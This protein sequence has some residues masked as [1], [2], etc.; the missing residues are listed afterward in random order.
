MAL[1]TVAP[2]T[3]SLLTRSARLLRLVRELCVRE[4]SHVGTLQD[5]VLA[6]AVITEGSTQHHLEFGH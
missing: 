6:I 5:L 4:P 1:L 2:L 3:V